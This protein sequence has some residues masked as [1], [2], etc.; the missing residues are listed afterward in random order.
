MSISLWENYS[1]DSENEEQNNHGRDNKI[2]N[3]A[4]KL[5]FL[6][7]YKNSEISDLKLEQIF[8]ECDYQDHLIQQSISKFFQQES[9]NYLTLDDVIKKAK[10]GK[11]NYYGI[12]SKFHKEH[13]F[14]HSKYK[15]KNKYFSHK[16]KYKNNQKFFTQEISLNDEYYDKN[17]D[18]NEED[19]D[20][21][22][23]KEDALN[24][25]MSKQKNKE[26]NE[27]KKSENETLESNNEISEDIENK[28]NNSRSN[29]NYFTVFQSSSNYIPKTLLY[30]DF[31]YIHG[32]TPKLF[33][34][35]FNQHNQDN[36]IHI[37]TNKDEHKISWNGIALY[38][39]CKNYFSK[40]K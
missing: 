39:N 22:N 20:D 11:N 24:E 18:K 34:G 2:I 32:Y 31:D 10:N 8:E 38:Y 28:S 7:K 13:K 4:T 35:I 30:G 33:P 25:I 1:D 12:N 27:S 3:E 21:Y 26:E 36:P 19:I 14:N 23:P 5:L 17:D 15:A 6:R 16:K 37:N 29:E 9:R 40:Y